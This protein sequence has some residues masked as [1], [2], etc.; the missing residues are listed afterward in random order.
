MYPSEIKG[1]VDSES[2][3]FDGRFDKK[4]VDNSNNGD[5]GNEGNEGF[6]SY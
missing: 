4:N 2:P 3:D 5:E 1:I 6:D